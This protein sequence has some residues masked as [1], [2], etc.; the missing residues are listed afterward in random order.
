[1]AV[2]TLR[3]F[4]EEGVDFCLWGN[5]ENGDEIEKTLPLPEEL[6]QRMRAWIGEYNQRTQEGVGGPWTQAAREDFDRRGYL[7]SL[8]VQEALGPAYK[9]RYLF[10]TKAVKGEAD[11]GAAPKGSEAAPTPRQL[12]E[13]IRAVAVLALPGDAQRDWLASRGGPMSGD[14]LTIDIFEAAPAVQ[15]F[16][17]AGW[18][19]KRGLEQVTELHRTLTAMSGPANRALWA[20]I[21]LDDAPEWDRVRRLARSVLAEL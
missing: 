14:A 11:A 6:R 8:E 13:M 5:G 12:G 20:P 21:Q 9:V 4:A 15:T 10:S 7:L 18:I 19:T 3:F 16:H 1:M 2:V 17:A